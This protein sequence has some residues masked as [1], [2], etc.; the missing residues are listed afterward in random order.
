[1]KIRKTPKWF[2]INGSCKGLVLALD[3]EYR[4]FLLNPATQACMNVPGVREWDLL[5]STIGLGY[6]SVAD[7][8]KVYVVTITHPR[9]V[10]VY[11]FKSNS[12]RGFRIALL[13]PLKIFI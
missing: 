11:N 6:D 8:Y 12:G 3:E 9:V 2:G 10:N 7:E 4:L 5:G 13:I 1:M